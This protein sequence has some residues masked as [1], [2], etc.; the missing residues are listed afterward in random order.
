MA[1]RTIA[2]VDLSR[3]DSRVSEIAAELAHAATDVGFLQVSSLSN[4]VGLRYSLL[5]GAQ[6]IA[7]LPYLSHAD[8]TVS[9][10]A[11]QH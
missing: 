8:R 10:G 9:C 6:L 1:G 11:T 2:C 5:K 3:F 4:D 7:V